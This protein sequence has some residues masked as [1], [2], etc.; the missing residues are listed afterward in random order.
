MAEREL[1]LPL[2]PPPGEEDRLDPRH[3][4]LREAPG[5]NHLAPVGSSQRVLVRVSCRG[6]VNL[7]RP[8]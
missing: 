1:L 7:C 3:H 5:R 2:S 6:S 4:A 8:R